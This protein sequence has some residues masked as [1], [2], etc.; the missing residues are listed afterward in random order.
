MRVNRVLSF[1]EAWN[2]NG[3]F[4]A[5]FFVYLP[6]CGV[7]L[8]SPKLALWHSFCVEKLPVCTNFACGIIVQKYNYCEA[9]STVG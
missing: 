2:K 4:R 7:N 5:S 6:L 1:S 9:I 3:V 8:C